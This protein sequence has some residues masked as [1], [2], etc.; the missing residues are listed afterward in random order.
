LKLHLKELGLPT[1]GKKADLLARL[2]E[3]ISTE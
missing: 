2:V 1:S 3:S